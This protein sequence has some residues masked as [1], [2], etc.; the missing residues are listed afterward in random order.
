MVVSSACASISLQLTSSSAFNA[1]FAS[2]LPHRIWVAVNTISAGPAARFYHC[3]EVVGKRIIVH[4][5]WNGTDIFDDV[6]I[7]NV[8]TFG[9]MQPKTGGF[10]PSPRYGHSLTLLPDGRLMMFGGV[11][12]DR[13]KGGVPQYHDDVRQLDTETMMWTRPRIAGHTPTG[14]FGHSATL[15]DDGCIVVFGGWGRGGCQCKERLVTSPCCEISKLLL[16]LCL[17]HTNFIIPFH[18]HAPLICYFQC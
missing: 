3:A 13:D 16:W 7:F 8:D 2:R 1:H 11:S 17:I 6:W 18:T 4:G 9:W 15:V 5:G 10:A 14:R 12:I